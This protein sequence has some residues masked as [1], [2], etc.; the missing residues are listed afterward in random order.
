MDFPCGKFG[1]FSFSPFGFIMWTDRQTHR[2]TNAVKC[3]TR[4]TV[5][6]MSNYIWLNFCKVRA[7]FLEFS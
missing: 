1:D 6:G 5:V 3:L 2:S 4:V 7:V